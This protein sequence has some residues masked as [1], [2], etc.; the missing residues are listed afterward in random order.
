[1]NRN[2]LP[3]AGFA[4]GRREHRGRPSVSEKNQREGSVSHATR[5]GWKRARSRRPRVNNGNREGPRG[6]G[7]RA[8]S[9]RA[10]R[11]GVIWIR[12]PTGLSLGLGYLSP[13]RLSAGAAESAPPATEYS[14][15]APAAWRNIAQAV[16]YIR[17][18][19]LVYT[20]APYAAPQ[21]VH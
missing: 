11:S 2:F 7:W 13:P 6:G 17:Y 1:M 12:G 8:E 5:R 4:K 21:C 16:P 3:D 14:R 20:P 9:E 18:Y 10:R 15:R 19:T